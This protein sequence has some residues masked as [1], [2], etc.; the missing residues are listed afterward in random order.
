[1]LAEFGSEQLELI[2]LSSL[3]ANATYGERVEGVIK[4]IQGVLPEQVSG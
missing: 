3:T 4:F 2:K 1:M